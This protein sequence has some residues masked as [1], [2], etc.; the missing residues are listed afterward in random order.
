VAVTA[1]ASQPQS[2]G[3]G[4]KVA[5]WLIGIAGVGAVGAGGYF[6]YMALDRFSK[7]QKKYDPS[8]EKEGKN[9]RLASG[10]LF[11][12]GGAAV[13]T[14]II[15]GATGGSSGPVALAPAVGPGVAGAMLS[16]SF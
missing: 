8:L 5:A 4:R 2:T 6:A 10:I 3:T 7:I 1:P 13:L 16:G 9:D 11:G 14:A 12:V 15:I